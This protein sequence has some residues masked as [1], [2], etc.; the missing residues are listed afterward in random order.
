MPSIDRRREDETGS[1]F[2]YS[3]CK[4]RMS[5][6]QETVSK[7]TTETATMLFQPQAAAATFHFH[8]WCFQSI[9]DSKTDHESFYKA[10]FCLIGHLGAQ[11]YR[12]WSIKNHIL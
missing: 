7:G 11:D 5:L 2:E 10:W 9:H 1:Q 4:S 6:A 12:H 3:S 8:N